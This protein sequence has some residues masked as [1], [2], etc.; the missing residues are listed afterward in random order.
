[1]VIYIQTIIAQYN[2]IKTSVI[3][4]WNDCNIIKTTCWKIYKIIINSECLS[5]ALL[6]LWSNCS[7]RRNLKRNTGPIIFIWTIIN[8]FERLFYWL[9]FCIIVCLLK[10]FQVIIITIHRNCYI[11][12]TLNTLTITRYFPF[13]ICYNSAIW[14]F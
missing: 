2:W 12:F 3:L 1:M 11:L 4:A 10:A 6:V 13:L 7:I 14:I 8:N 5:L 9:I